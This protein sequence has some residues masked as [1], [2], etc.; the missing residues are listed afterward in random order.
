MGNEVIRA[1][2]PMPLSTLADGVSGMGQ[3]VL[4]LKMPANR[5]REK[6]EVNTDKK[7]CCPNRSFSRS[8]RRLLADQLQ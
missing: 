8:W 4:S 2:K 7:Y 3:P 5:N 1:L 6:N